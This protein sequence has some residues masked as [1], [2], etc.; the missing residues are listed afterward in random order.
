MIWLQTLQLKIADQSEL[1]HLIS[2]DLL[3]RPTGFEP[4]TYGLEGRCSIQ[5]SYGRQCATIL[6]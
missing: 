1:F 6:E 5:L 4:V 3:V 2:Q